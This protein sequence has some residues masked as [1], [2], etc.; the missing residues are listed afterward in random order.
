[1]QNNYI[2]MNSNNEIL[3]FYYG[4][5]RAI[6]CRKMGSNNYP[7]IN[8]II[9]DV[10]DFF[11]VDIGPNKE[12]YIFC[13]NYSGDIII[14]K[15]EQEGFKNKILFKNKSETP[16]NILFYPIFFKGNMSLIYNTSNK[17]NQFLSIKTLVAG[18]NWTN[19]EN[20]DLF[21]MLPNNVFYV[22]KLTQD[23]IIIAYQK[24]AK[25]IQIGYKQ[26]SNGNISEFITIHKTGYQIVDYS[27]IGH[28]NSVHYIYIIKTLFSSQV[29][30]KRKDERGISSQIILFE[31]QKI[32]Y[33]NINILNNNL[34]CSFIVNNTLFYCQS[35]DFGI[36][37][38]GIAKYKKPISSDVVKARFVSN[39]NMQNS[40]IN[41]IFIDSKNPLN[42]YM[43]PE[44]LPSV[45][46]KNEQI[47]QDKQ[48]IKYNQNENFITNL[49]NHFTNSLDSKKEDIQINKHIVNQPKNTVTLEN[50]FMANFNLDQFS[51]F[52]IPEEKIN[53]NE[54]NIDNNLI[55]ENRLK[56]LNEQLIEKNSQI[57]KLNNIIQNKNNEK[58][59]IEIGLRQKV[60][61][62]ENENNELKQKIF[63]L[64][65]Q[66]QTLNDEKNVNKIVESEVTINNEQNLHKPQKP[67]EEN[68]QP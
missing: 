5:E 35:E 48:D 31:G 27:F 28:E 25:D 22:Q 58:T 34:Y 52:N 6:Y 4:E 38:L 21:S 41:E 45:F 54:T 40:Y 46:N 53:N 59:D 14:C 9:E 50:D 33:C 56:I 67:I 63:T 26:I 30:Y 51:N 36:S 61:Y 20:I 57:L 10:T 62:M 8:K 39:Y 12:I 24:K 23:N 2:L 60:K 11:T 37:F 68:E 18:K 66:L 47:K 17:T 7:I 13:Q 55:L 65:N 64:Q 3:S 19:A 29:I 42:I 43:L 16:E 44:F 32:K 49:N 15:L 1:M